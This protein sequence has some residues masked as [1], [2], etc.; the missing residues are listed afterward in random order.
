MQPLYLNNSDDTTIT[1]SYSPTLRCTHVSLVLLSVCR[2][3][4][5]NL[6]EHMHLC[7]SCLSYLLYAPLRK[8][9]G[10]KRLNM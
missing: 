8:E 1:L 7:Y 2:M 10:W 9:C 3:Q 6:L 5:K 4:E